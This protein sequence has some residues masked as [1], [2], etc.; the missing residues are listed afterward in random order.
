[1][2]AR[3]ADATKIHNK[4]S[5]ASPTPTTDGTRLYVH[6]GHMGTAALDLQGKVLWT[7]TRL[8]DKPVHGN[9]GSPILVDGKLVFSC[10]GLDKQ[11]V[12][13]L[14]VKT[15]KTIW[16]TPRPVK[17]IKPFSFS[18]PT[19]ID[20]DGKEQILSVGTDI[21]M[22]LEP[23]AGKIV[24]QSKFNGYSVIPKP[25]VGQGMV[26]FSTVYD[27]P[28]LR[29]VK[30]GGE[31]DV[32]R[33]NGVWIDKRSA[34][35]TPS[36]ILSGNELFAI[37]DAGLLTCLDAKTG[38]HLWQERLKAQ[39]S[40]SPIPPD[41]ETY[42]TSETGQGTVAEASRKFNKFRREDLG[43]KTFASFAAADGALYVRTET[44]LYK[45]VSR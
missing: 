33:E 19:V 32:T 42:L 25:V 17:S 37:S 29:A 44:Q 24:W 43:E 3:A 41:G 6:F 31:G 9:G 10:D 27:R 30:L 1:M 21:V 34:P 4:N 39:Y 5:P 14:D 36:M 12:V 18:T 26:Y 8:Y 2:L 23:T 38:E 11:A 35:N 20:V 40:A 15:G 16:E 22:A 13:A 7:R 45:F 28:E